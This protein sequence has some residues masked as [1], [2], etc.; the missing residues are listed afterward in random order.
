MGAAGEGHGNLD[1]LAIGFLLGEN[2]LERRGI[3]AGFGVLIFIGD[4]DSLAVVIEPRKEIHRH[5]HIVLRHL[6]GRDQIGHRRENMGTIDAVCLRAKH[7]IVTRGTPRR[8]FGDRDVRQP[9][10]VE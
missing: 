6:A 9:I 8:L 4:R 10:F 5:R 1:F 2:L 7:D 3:E